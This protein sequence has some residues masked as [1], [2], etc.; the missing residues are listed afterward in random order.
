MHNRF[1]SSLSII[2]AAWTSLLNALRSLRRFALLFL[3]H[4]ATCAP[5]IPRECAISSLS[6]G[7]INF[8]VTNRVWSW[9]IC[10]LVKRLFDFCVFLSSSVVFWGR[11]LGARKHNIYYINNLIEILFFFKQTSY[12]KWQKGKEINSTLPLELEPCKSWINTN[13][14]LLFHCLKIVPGSLI[15]ILLCTSRFDW[16]YETFEMCF[17]LEKGEKLSTQVAQAPWEPWTLLWHCVTALIWEFAWGCS[18]RISN[19][20]RLKRKRNWI[21]TTNSDSSVCYYIYIY[22]YIPKCGQ[23]KS[24]WG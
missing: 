9:S 6:N 7:E 14:K 3:N 22:I 24:L 23:F 18:N 21:K 17:Q 16:D 20:S 19:S 12:N 4:V 13:L 15:F 5:E 8:L 2:F 1:I 11:L 10:C